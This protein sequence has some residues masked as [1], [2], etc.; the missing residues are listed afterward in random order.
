ML[1]LDCKTVAQKIKDD[2][3]AV[4]QLNTKPEETYKRVPVLCIIQVGDNPASNAYIRGKMKDAEEVGIKV[5]HIKLPEETTTSELRSE[6]NRCAYDN[7]YTLGGIRYRCSG[8]IVQLPLPKHIDMS[9]IDINE[10][11]DVDGFGKKSN[12]SPCTPSGVM[13][14]I[15]SIGYDLDGKTAMIIGQSAI[16]GR[17]LAEMFME[18]HCNVVSIN[19]SMPKSTRYDILLRADVLV[20]AAGRMNLITEDDFDYKWCN[21]INGYENSGSCP[22][23]IIDV[24]INYKDGKQ[25]GDCDETLRSDKY[26]HCFDI[27]PRIGG[28]GLLTRAKLMENVAISCYGAK[29][30]WFK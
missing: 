5:N 2:V 6:I 28:V 14:L 13:E 16:V 1:I 26:S 4:I 3:K 19:S 10:Y 8:I 21:A 27:T 15:D 30:Y 12:Y 22:E 20:T 9:E 7:G 11:Y 18:R 25:Y 24:G 23:L 17:P 29:E